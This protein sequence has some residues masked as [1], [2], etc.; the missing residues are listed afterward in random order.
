MHSSRLVVEKGGTLIVLLG[1]GVRTDKRRWAVPLQQGGFEREKLLPGSLL[2]ALEGAEVRH[3]THFTGFTSGWVCCG[4]I[5]P[6]PDQSDPTFKWC[7]VR[8]QVVSWCFLT[9]FFFTLNAHRYGWVNFT[10]SWLPGIYVRGPNPSVG[11]SGNCGWR[12][13]AAPVNKRL[14]LWTPWNLPQTLWVR[15]WGPALLFKTIVECIH[16]NE[17]NPTKW[18]RLWS[19]V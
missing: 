8:H 16:D 14:W 17:P 18:L 9:F 3:R 15:Q 10:S 5:F 2:N 13:E 4:G 1:Q 6:H 7:N 11:F 19:A 12:R